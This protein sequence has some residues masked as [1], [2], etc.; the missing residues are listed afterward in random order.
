MKKRQSEYQDVQYVIILLYIALETKST[1]ELWKSRYAS[2]SFTSSREEKI[3]CN[4]KVTSRN[5]KKIILF[6]DISMRYHHVD[7]RKK[8]LLEMHK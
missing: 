2:D 7:T 6:E 5:K 3:P 4:G 1:V 8:T